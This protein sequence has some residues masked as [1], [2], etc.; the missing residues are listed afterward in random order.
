MAGFISTFLASAVRCA[1]PM[2]IAALGLVFSERA[3]IVNIGVEG[4]MIIGA[5]LAYAGS[6][7]TGSKWL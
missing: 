1:M 5:I 6:F 3:G 4:M 7:L 2:F